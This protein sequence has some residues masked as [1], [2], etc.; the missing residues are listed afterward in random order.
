M[1][2]IILAIVFPAGTLATA[3][4]LGLGFRLPLH[5]W[6]AVKLWLGSLVA[7]NVAIWL[8]L[9]GG[10]DPTTSLTYAQ[11]YYWGDFICQVLGL[12]VLLRLAEIA[13]GKSK[14]SIPMLRGITLA[15][16]VGCFI[17]SFATIFSRMGVDSASLKG[18]DQF[19]LEAEQ[20]LGLVG[21][22]AAFLIWPALGLM[23][24]PGVRIRRLV[25]AFAV[26]YS[27]GSVGWALVAIFGPSGVGSMTVPLLNI[28]A[29]VLFA[30]SM[31][32]PDEESEAGRAL[33]EARANRRRRVL[34]PAGAHAAAQARLA[35][36][37]ALAAIKSEQ[38]A[39]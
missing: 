36:A 23:K 26:M 8:L 19:A 17:V 11:T 10:A 38:G 24:I 9:W 28:L 39:A 16:I 22:F 15:V 14:L 31:A 32:E 29:M 33:A 27:S 21:M 25:A 4:A 18:L 1:D 5:R 6:L 3:L 37:A 35:H 2:S 20:N 13:F 12:L 30:I 7:F 34:G